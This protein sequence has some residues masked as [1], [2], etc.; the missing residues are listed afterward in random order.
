MPSNI[1]IK[2]RASDLS[3]KH[4]LAL[5]VADRPPVMLQQEDTFFPCG[6]GRLKLRRLSDAEGELIFYARPDIAGIKQS[7]YSLFRTSSPDSLLAVLAAASDARIVVKKTRWLYLVGQTRIH[8]DEV[9]GL[10]TFVE[11]EVVLDETES[12]DD[13][14]KTARKLMTALEIDEADLIDCAYADLLE[15]A[16]N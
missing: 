6:K 4:E 2:A 1:E 16:A 11:L 12:A 9:A 14:R 7:H 15:S 10:G 13:G 3:R 5:R 8:L